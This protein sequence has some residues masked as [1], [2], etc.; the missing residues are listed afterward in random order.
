MNGYIKR[1]AWIAATLLGW[2]VLSLT[3]HAASFDCAKSLTQIEKFICADAALSKLDEELNAAYKT[4]LR[5][6]KRA[7]AIKQAQKQ[8]IWGRNG[9]PTSD[10]LKKTYQARIHELT[11]T[12]DEAEVLPQSAQPKE[13]NVDNPTTVKKVSALS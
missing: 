6:G 11:G 12:P 13:E 1:S 3:A 5:D 7:D 10:C 4:A 2:V 8:W 9:C